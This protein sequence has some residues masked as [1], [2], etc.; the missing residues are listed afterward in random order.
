MKNKIV[1]THCHLD[2]PDFEDDLDNVIN[3]AKKKG[4]DFFLTISI[5]LEKFNRIYNIT[6]KYKNVWCST[7][8]HPNNV[9]LNSNSNLLDKLRNQLIK[10][11]SQDKVIG[12]GETGLDFFRN[13]NNKKNQLDYFHTHMV[14]SG[15]TKSPLIIHTRSADKETI[16]FLKNYAVKYNI[17]GLLHCFSSSRKL[18]KIA[19]D[20]GFYISFSGLATYKNSENIQDVLKFI[21]LDRLLVE[22][23]SPYLSPTPHRGERN[24]PANVVYTLKKISEIKNINYEMLAEITTKNFFSLFNNIKN[25]N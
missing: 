8:V 15:E 24:E 2:F 4:V 22:T 21:P 25:E 13:E 6:Q 14:V 16:N 17:K 18:A 23:D 19:L 10:N 11:I 12:I 1:D 7:G 9:P 3:N 20:N 5:N